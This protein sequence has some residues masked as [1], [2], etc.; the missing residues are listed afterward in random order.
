MSS[1]Q[2]QRTNVPALVARV[3]AD[4]GLEPAR[5]DLEIT[6]GIVVADFDAVARDLRRLL[7]LGVS[8]S[9]DDFGT[10]YSAL[11]YASRLPVSRLKIDQSFVRNLRPDSPD[12][13]IVRTIMT[14][15]RSLDMKVLA[16]GVETAEQLEVLRAEGC[17][18]AQGFFFSRPLPAR[19]FRD[20]IGH[21]DD[22]RPAKRASA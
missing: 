18:E 12:V 20:L 8:I 14:L 9:I 17:E 5:L 6:E 2:F 21:V 4:C 16:E 3:L 22:D 11:N 7:D 19:A 1:I 10:G 15:G 13:A